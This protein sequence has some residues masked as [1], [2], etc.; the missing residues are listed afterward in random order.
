MLLCMVPNAQPHTSTPGKMNPSGLRVN[1]RALQQ[2]H[3]LHS[4]YHLHSISLETEPLSLGMW[5]PAVGQKRSQ[6]KKAGLLD[7]L[8]CLL[9]L[10][11]FYTQLDFQASNPH[12]NVKGTHFA[13]LK[14]HRALTLVL[15]AGALPSVP[16]HTVFSEYPRENLTTKDLESRVSISIT[17]GALEHLLSSTHFTVKKSNPWGKNSGTNSILKSQGISRL[18][19]YLYKWKF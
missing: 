19:I 9:S 17:V 8:K 15:Y 13:P 18:Q 7:D 12:P 10:P 2:L 5:Q 11:S 14:K 3:H 4:A 6:E 16:M 1:K